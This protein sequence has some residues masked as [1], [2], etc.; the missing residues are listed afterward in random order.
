MLM[1]SQEI[2]QQTQELR[3]TMIRA[4]ELADKIGTQLPETEEPALSAQCNVIRAFLLQTKL[5]E[6]ALDDMLQTRFNGVAKAD[7]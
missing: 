1:I 3:K 5:Q 4:A 2:L 7:K 6:Q